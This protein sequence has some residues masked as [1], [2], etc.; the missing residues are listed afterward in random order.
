M[1]RPAFDCSP[2][3]RAKN[4]ASY[5]AIALDASG[6]VPCTCADVRLAAYRGGYVAPSGLLGW[7]YDACARTVAAL[8]EDAR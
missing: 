7:H 8:R 3:V 5:R 4:A 6:S 1:M 2:A